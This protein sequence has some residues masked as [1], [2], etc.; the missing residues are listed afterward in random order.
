MVNGRVT[1]CGVERWAVKTSMDSSAHS[2]HTT[3]VINTTIIHLR[4]FTPPAS[5]PATSRVVPT[6]TSVF[7]I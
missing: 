5:L 4:S 3:H 6:E 7:R 2:V 1:A